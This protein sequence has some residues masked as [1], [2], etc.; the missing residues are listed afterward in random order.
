MV[1]KMEQ[2][3]L[4]KQNYLE[5]EK[6]GK[7]ETLFCLQNGYISVR[8]VDEL[9]GTPNTPAAFVA[10]VFDSSTALCSMMAAMPY[11]LGYEIHVDHEK[12]SDKGCKLISYQRELNMFENCLYAEYLFE[13]QDGKQIKV[14]E[15]KFVSVVDKN[16]SWVKIEVTLLNFSGEV[17]L[18]S[19]LDCTAV[20]Y[21]VNSNKRFKTFTIEELKPSAN[22]ALITVTTMDKK[23][24]VVSAVCFENSFLE[25]AEVKND[26]DGIRHSFQIHCNQNET[27]GMKKAVCTY[28]TTEGTLCDIKERAV[29]N[30]SNA[31]SSGF[32]NMFAN[33][34]G[35]MKALWNK[36]DIKIDGDDELQIATRFNIMTL[37]LLGQGFHSDVNIGAKGLHGDGYCGRTFWDTEIFLLPYYIYTD[38]NAA[39]NLVVYRMK[40]LE[41]AKMN[42][43]EHG[44]EGAKF[45]W[46][47]SDTG[48]E[49][50]PDSI[51]LTTGEVVPVLDARSQLHITADVA[52]GL[53]SYYTATHD[54]SILDEYGYEA[55]HQTVLYWLSVVERNE[56]KEIYEILGVK[57][58]DEFHVNVSNNFYTNYLVRWNLLWA[59]QLFEE[60]RKAAQKLGITQQDIDRWREIASKIYVNESDG[61]I[62]QFDG[63]FDLKDYIIAEYDEKFMPKLPET[64]RLESDFRPYTLLKQPD[65]LMILYM[66]KERFPYHQKA[67]NFSYYEKRTTHK[68]SL[69][70]CIR[71]LV[72][73][74]IGANQ[75]AYEY[76]KIT[77]CVDIVDN[78]NNTYQG[79]HAAS[80]GGAWQDLV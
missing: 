49:E 52:Y 41:Q 80:Q 21:D 77:A 33:H 68:S 22:D 57:G 36:H 38:I 45:P 58:P 6:S 23:Y 71:A 60:N 62:E 34:R 13:K 76:F 28:A 19:K 46:Q 2:K 25:S 53:Y 72:G 37:M 3:I 55:I 18:L 70:P 78:Q 14:A 17:E 24:S 15:S 7:Y 48:L 73:M 10:G 42:A 56:K 50:C 74:N 43:K 35:S 79:I 4:L 65:V 44:K 54:Q 20:N 47:S 67:D 27:Y 8:G 30:S 31:K 5:R 1:N 61:I 51:C 32:D 69:S 40:R 29:I 12:I 75:K 9:V 59:I 26:A 64:F 63:F 66:F 16:T 39:R 11:L